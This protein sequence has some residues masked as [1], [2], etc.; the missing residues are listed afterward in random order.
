ML[1]CGG[2]VEIGGDGDGDPFIAAKRALRSSRICATLLLPAVAVEPELLDSAGE[3]TGLTAGL[4]VEPQ[5]SSCSFQSSV[6]GA[7]VLILGCGLDDAFVGKEAVTTGGL[8]SAETGSS[9]PS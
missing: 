8:G 7:S 2:G 1:F 9:Q 6:A 5:A 4:L 3:V